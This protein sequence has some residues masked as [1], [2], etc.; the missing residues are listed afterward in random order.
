[1]HIFQEDDC[2]TNIPRLGH[3]GQ[4]AGGAG[5]NE[6]CW[7]GVPSRLACCTIWWRLCCLY[8]LIAIDPVSDTLI[9]LWASTLPSCY[10][11]RYGVA[12][13]FLICVILVHGFVPKIML[14]WTI[15]DI[16][17]WRMFILCNICQTLVCASC[18][19]QPPI[20]P[21]IDPRHLV[22]ISLDIYLD[23]EH[24]DLVS[25]F[26]LCCYLHKMNFGYLSHR[27]HLNLVQYIFACLT[28]ICHWECS[29][30]FVLFFCHRY[31]EQT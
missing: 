26:F 11:C 24:G 14:L 2:S 21:T 10:L 12:P 28:W 8:H 5:D 23:V 6:Q 17:T 3:C 7:Q 30:L 27:E 18:Q 9:L 20:Y 15:F 19:A 25:V 29:S 1:M 31:V 4:T 22:H 16:N 13:C